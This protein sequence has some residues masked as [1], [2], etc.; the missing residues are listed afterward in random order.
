LPFYRVF[1]LCLLLIPFSAGAQ[2][3][4]EKTQE[5]AQKLQPC[6]VRIR[7]IESD[8]REGR[9][10]RQEAFG[11]GVIVTPDGC[12]VTNHHVAGKA[13]WLTATLSDRTEVD[14]KLLGTDPLADV[15]VIKLAPRKDGKP[16]AV[17]SWGDSSRLKVGQRVLAI[18]CPYAFS[19]SV[20]S[21]IVSNTELT[22]PEATAGEMEM[23]GEDVGS[24]VRWI[25]HDAQIYPG[26]S[27]GALVN[28][29]GEVVGINEIKLGLSGAI[30]AN[31][32]KE[33]VAQIIASGSVQRASF[34]MNLQA[35][36]KDSNETTGEL[37]G[38][39]EPGSPAE[40]AGIK[41]GDILLSVGDVAL[42][43]PFREVEPVANLELARLTVG[44]TYPVRVLRA[45]AEKTLTITPEAR[46]PALLPNKEIHEWGFTVTDLTPDMARSMNLAPDS[47]VL[48]TTVLPGGPSTEAQPAL[49][50]NDVIAKVSNLAIKNRDDLKK[51]TAGLKP[52]D[53]GTPTLVEFIR[54][55]EHFMTVVSVGKSLSEDSAAEV[56]HPWLPVETQVVTDSL[57]HALELPDGTKGVRLTLIYPEGKDSGLKVGDIITSLDGKSIDVSLPE[58]NHFFNEMIRDFPMGAEVK[59][60]GFRE[61][62]PLNSVVKLKPSKKEIRD[63]PRFVLDDLGFTLRE[64]TYKDGES[65]PPPVGLIAQDVVHGS[66]A[67]VAGLEE[68]DIVQSIDGVSVRKL[69]DAKAQIAALKAAKKENIVL[70]VSKDG[71]TAFL[72]L[73]TDWKSQP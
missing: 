53:G 37:V 41:A 72:E 49:A 10:Q 35:R 55:G 5:I 8:A 22:M 34:G 43:V 29:D 25:G 50:P 24:I 28:L 27:G 54:K 36:L 11:S 46:K 59:V 17:A 67:E 57:A 1:A 42:D 38:G 2:D 30:P 33:V 20:T 62:K 63:L 9:E 40:R 6:L 39:V 15:A 7:V 66:W 19:Q 61:G 26:N 65:G 18:G 70:F 13:L 52:Q 71:V 44:K 3:L 51:F 68:G 45:G 73:R 31:L 16:Y 56:A 14:A 47:G 12:V 69:Q 58:D 48:I 21:G 23:D 60:A 4:G 32:A 64:T